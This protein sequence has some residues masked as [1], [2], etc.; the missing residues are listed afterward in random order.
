MTGKGDFQ[1]KCIKLTI[2]STF[3][4]V[5]SPHITSGYTS[6]NIPLNHWSY[7]A[8][9]RLVAS[10]IVNTAMLNKR[11]LTRMDMA[12]MLSKIPLTVYIESPIL[13]E[14]MRKLTEEYRDELARLGIVPAGGQP[15]WYRIA[16]PVSWEVDFADMEGLKRTPRE[17]H[18]GE[19]F[20][21]GISSRILLR[22]WANLSDDIV[23][24]IAPKL[25]VYRGGYDA[26]FQEAY[27]KASISNIEL[28]IGRDSLWWGPGYHGSLI[29]SNNASPFNLIKLS[30]HRPFSLPGWFSV[31][32]LWDISAYITRLEDNRDFPRAKLAGLR[33]G[34][35]P[36]KFMEISLTR[37][38]IFDGEGRPGLDLP[39]YLKVFFAIGEN[40]T[41]KLNNDQLGGID[42]RMAIPVKS[43]SE[44]FS[45][46]GQLIGED[47]A[48]GL[49]SS[50][51]ILGG[52]FI[53][54]IFHLGLFDIRM[55]YADQPIK[56][57]DGP[58]YRHG[59]YTTGYTYHRR[60]IGYPMGFEDDYFSGSIF[61]GIDAW[62]IFSR[63]TVHMGKDIDIA[64]QYDY[65]RHMASAPINE[66]KQEV[67]IDISWR[68]IDNVSL[69]MGQ[70]Y[71]WIDNW[72]G[73]DGE[74]LNNYYMWGRV[75]LYR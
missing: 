46:Y 74:E 75:E 45:L 48:G 61:G 54:D 17:N 44:G 52:V 40:E 2:F 33:L 49:P 34:L 16:D 32:G 35:I 3:F 10:G 43:L 51:G 19:Y 70:V 24:D 7:E 39:D 28:E 14:D 22:T 30:S 57:E 20:Y 23:V 29:L 5:F 69:K 65:E 26:I 37:S 72:R 50:H 66:K 25:L 4:L 71:E 9:E 13:K 59:V 55:E 58:R 38:I 47:E 56:D 18:W 53:C 8:M 12:G 27:A 31:L 67:A 6:S 68:I 15:R 63:V 42:F 73:I 64:L 62:D 21:D 41:G 1:V 60:V 11:P 36:A